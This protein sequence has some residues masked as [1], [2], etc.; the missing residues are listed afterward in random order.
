MHAHPKCRVTVNPGRGLA[1]HGA[2]LLAPLLAGCAGE[3]VGGPQ[4][5]ASDL[6]AGAFALVIDTRTGQVEVTPPR[7]TSSAAGPAY[8]L[9]GGDGV[10][11]D[12]DPCAFTPIP[13]N[14]RR[15]RCTFSLRIENRLEATDL[16]T[17]TEFPR[18]PAGV[19]GILVFP[20]TASA[21]GG[22]EAV[23]VPSPAWDRQPANF[24]NDFG[25]CASGNKSDCYRYEVYGSP[26]YA[27]DEESREVGF[28][29][30]VDATSVTAYVVVAA[31]LCVT[32]LCTSFD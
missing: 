19:T 17:P 6:P 30:P 23:A 11:L 10:A 4:P 5:P 27:G 32:T 31:D 14:P 22:T 9:I 3:R 18:P 20:L 29:V 12:A 25:S 2:I 7:A 24:F 21:Q 15:K 16:V 28:D 13:G 26:L 8:S 1:S